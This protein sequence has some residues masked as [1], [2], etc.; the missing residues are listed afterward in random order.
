M[1]SGPHTT[2]HTVCHCLGVT[3]S[4]LRKTIER[5]DMESVRQ[6]MNYTNAGTGCTACHPAIRALLAQAHNK[7]RAAYSSPTCVTR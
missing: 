1:A 6:I 7:R 4:H 3:A 2:N 5:G